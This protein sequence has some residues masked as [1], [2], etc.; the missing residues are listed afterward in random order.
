MEKQTKNVITRE[1]IEKELRF[2]NT[3]YIR[4]TLVLCAGL[5]LLFVPLTVLAVCGVCVAF[6]AVLLEIII[7]VLLGSVL[8]APVWINLLCLIP[9]LKERKLLQNGDFVIAVCE[10]SYKEKKTVRRHTENVLHFVGFDG[11]SVASTTFDLASQGDEFYVVHYKGLTGIELL[12]SLNL[13]E[14]Q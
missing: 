14:L 13:Y 8:S 4:S 1:F 7:S 2:Y 11:A 3:A 5:S 6:T 10:M 9:K 12:Y